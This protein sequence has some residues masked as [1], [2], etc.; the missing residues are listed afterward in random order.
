MPLKDVTVIRLRHVAS[1]GTGEAAVNWSHRWLVRGHWRQQRCKDDSGAWTTRPVFIHPY[2]KG[3][4][5]APLLSRRHVNH[6]VR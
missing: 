5:E 2:I 1:R 4:E 3:P 6:L